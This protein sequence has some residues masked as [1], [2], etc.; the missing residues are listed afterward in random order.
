MAATG[1]EVTTLKQ[2]KNAV[3]KKSAS[4]ATETSYGTVKL[5]SDE[6]F[7]TY[8][9]STSGDSTV[10][11]QEVFTLSQLKSV[12]SDISSGGGSG[13]PDSGNVTLWEGT[14]IFRDYDSIPLNLSDNP[15]NYNRI[16][17]ST[18]H[19]GGSDTTIEYFY[20][21]VGDSG[22]TYPDGIFSYFYD[23]DFIELMN[24]TS[25][26]RLVTKITGIK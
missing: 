12:L 25:A 8:V 17:I 4:P 9:N 15:S 7:E 20:P 19:A 13:G 10:T 11:G 26:Y 24:L 3:A 22:N 2:F 14:A 23:T 1:N 16:E 6:D 21:S 18:S 5:I